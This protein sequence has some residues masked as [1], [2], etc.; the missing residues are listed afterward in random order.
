MCPESVSK[1]FIFG[2]SKA[3]IVVAL[4]LPNVGVKLLNCLVSID[5]HVKYVR[6]MVLFN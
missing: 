6:D 5:V 4:A 2:M 3:I 1:V